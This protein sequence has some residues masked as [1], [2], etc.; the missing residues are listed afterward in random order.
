MPEDT[1]RANVIESRITGAEVIQVAGLISDAAA[2]A[3]RDGKALGWFDVSTFK[4]PYRVEGKKIMG[5]ELAETGNWHLPDVIIYP[6]GGGTGLVGM[7]KAFAELE[8]WV[9]WNSQRTCCG[10]A[11]GCAPVASFQ[12]SGCM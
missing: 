8:A 2:R 7:W 10:Q 5:Y 4:E 1:P 6:T 12:N 3:D 11:E 9:G